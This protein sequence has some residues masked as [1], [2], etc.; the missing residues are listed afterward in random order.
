VG[1]NHGRARVFDFRSAAFALALLAGAGLVGASLISGSPTSAGR[2]DEF[3]ARG[4]S[5]RVPASAG[6]GGFDTSFAVGDDVT[7]SFGVV[8]V[9]HATAISGLQQDEISGGH[10]AANLVEPG[11]IEVRVGATITNLSS[12]VLPFA[13]GQFE[14]LD[15]D[16][17]VVP[18]SRVP[19]LPSELQPSASLEMVLGFV[20]TTQARPFTVR[21]ADPFSD[22]TRAIGLGTVGCEVNSGSGRPLPHDAGCST[23][24][25][26][27]DHGVRHEP[28]RTG[29]QAVAPSAEPLAVGTELAATPSRTSALHVWGL[30]L[31]VA[32]IF[33]VAASLRGSF[34]R[35]TRRGAPR[36][37]HDPL[38]TVVRR[39]RTAVIGLCLGAFVTSG[40][41]TT[42][43]GGAGALTPGLCPNGAALRQY[44]VRAI[45]VDIPLN[46]YGDHDPLGIMYA[47][48]SE[49]PAI[50]AQE[51]SGDVTPGLGEDPIQP[52]V[53][54]A[55]EGDC[56]EITLHN[57][58][59]R[60]SL[61][62]S[63]DGLPSDASGD[64]VGDN[65]N[66]EVLPGASRSYTYEIPNDPALEG[67][68]YLHP[69][70]G[71]R[72]LVDHGLFGA[73]VV[74]PPAST[75]RSQVDSRQIQSGWAAIIAPGNGDPA[76][77]ENVKIVHEVGN[78]SETIIGANGLPLPTVDPTTEAYRPGSRAFNYRA[79]PFMNRLLAQPNAKSHAYSTT[80]FGDPATIVA[81]GYV[82]EPTKFRV[83][84]AG[85][86]VFHVY[87]LHGGGDRWRLNP[88]A[89]PT[90]DYANTGL[91]KQPVEASL[92]QRVDAVST[93]PGESF[94]A[95]IE[96]GAG[97]VQQAAG[98]FLFH[99]HIAEHYPSGM[100]GLWRVFD[101]RQPGV[102][103]ISEATAPPL[104]V[105]S[106]QLIGRT[107]PGGVTLTAAN[108]AQWINPQL[109]PRGVPVDS[110]DATVWDWT[111][112]TIAGNPRYLGEPE[113][114]TSLPPGFVDGVAGHPG[115]FPG[116]Q[117]VGTRPAIL[118]NPTNG[119]PAFPLLR[120]HS[121][122]RPPFAPNE[123]SGAPWLGETGNTTSPGVDPWANRPDGL[124]PSTA[125]VKQFNIVAIN[126]P[127]PV[128]S[129]QSDA[130]GGIFTLAQDKAAILGGT[131]PVE[132]LA[133]RANVGDCVD[134]ILSSELQDALAF[135]G[136]SKVE[137]HI[138][139]VQFDPQG[140]DG[141]AAG[142]NFEHSI[143][144]YAATDTQLAAPAAIGATSV[145]V[146]ALRPRYRPGVAIAI[147]LGH[148]SVEN[149]TIAS[150]NAATNT[151]TLTEPLQH[152]HAIGEG[153]GT[154]FVR[155]R[156]YADGL[157]D[158]IFWHDHVDGIHGWGHGFVGM[159]IVEPR[160]STYTDPATG[161]PL[162]SGT[163]AD[164]HYN[165]VA[166][167]GGGTSAPLAP[168][169]VDGDFR[170]LVL[171]TIDDSPVTDSTIN[172]RAE[173]F[174]GRGADPSLWFS[175]Y[176]WGDPRTPLLRAYPGDSVV[177]RTVHV[178]PTIDS[179]RVDGHRF[180]VENRARDAVTGQRW[181]RVTDTM[182]AGVS[183]RFTLILDGGAGG[184]S[185]APGDYLY[186][187]GVS[188][189]F[190]QGAWGIMRVLPATSATLQPLANNAA[191]G[192]SYTA[193]SVTGTRPPALSDA[194]NPCPAAAYAAR[195]SFAVSA[196]RFPNSTGLS[197]RVNYAYVPT[198]QAAAAQLGG[199]SNPYVLHVNR[200][201]CI[202]INF[203]NDSNL[204]HAGF[205]VGELS[206]SAGS[207]GVNVGWNE[208]QTVAPGETRDYVFYADE[209]SIEAALV[210]DP[211]S[212]SIDPEEPL[213]HPVAAKNGLYGAIV[214]H[215]A[216]A[217]FTNPVSG[218]PT[219]LGTIVDVH[220]GAESYRDATL[221]LADDDV[222]LGNDFMPYPVD[223]QNDPM[224]NYRQ[225]SLRTNSFAG[226]PGTPIVRAYAGDPVKIHV[227]AA[228]GSEQPHAFH[229]SGH[230]WLRDPY[231]EFSEPGGEV[232]H[233]QE[234]STQMVAPNSGIDIHLIEGAGGRHHQVRDYWYGDLRRPFAEGGMWGLLRVMSDTACPIHALPTR[235]CA[236]APGGT[237]APVFAADLANRTD[238]EGSAISLSAAATDVDGDALVYAAT[239]LPPGLSIDPSSGLITG[240]LPFTAAGS[241]NVAITVRDGPLV[242]A[243]DTFTWTVSNT[244]RDPLFGQDLLDRTDAEADSISISSA[245]TDPDLEV[246]TYSA[247]GLPDGVSINS[248]TGLISGT[249]TF[250][251]AGLHNVAIRATDTAGGEATD[252]FTWTV[253]NVNREPTF[254]QDLGNRS[255][256]E[257][258]AVSLSAA[259][260][261][262]DGDP[263]T[264]AATNLPLGLTIDTSTGLITGTVSYVAAANS[265]Y[266]VTITVRD[267]ATIDATDSFVWTV[268][269][270]N[271]D[272]VF[273]QNLPDRSDGEGVTI[274]LSAA[275]TDLDGDPLTYAATNLPPGL[276]IDTST[277]LI[278]GTLPFTAAGL[279]SVTITVR[280]G[281]LVD[282]TDA[283][284]WTVTNTNREPTFNQNLGN[285]TDSE[286]ASVSLSA[287]ATDP[288]GD[289]LTYAATG[290]PAG[291]SINPTTGLIQGTLSFA[292]AGTHGVVVTV[293]DGPTID[294]ADSFTWTVLNVN[295]E[296]TFDQDLGDRATVEG[297]AV[298][299]SASATDPDGDALMYAAT[300]LPAGLAINTST[301][302]ISGTVAFT[303]AG[304]HTVS[305]TVRDGV[306]VDA[307]DTFTWTIID[308]PGAP[309]AIST[310]PGNAQ[311]TVLWLA[312]TTNGG[313]PITGYIVTPL[314][315]ST[316][317]T[318]RTFNS[319]ATTQ[320]ITGLTNGT[321]YTFQV[322]AFNVNG[323]G[324][325]SGNAGSVTVGTP[326]N[327]TNPKAV[328][329]N[330]AATVSWTA[331]TT[332]NGAA[333]TGYRVTPYIG[334]TAQTTVT[335]GTALSTTI[336]G[337]TNG[338]AYTFKIA[339]INS[340]GTGP[341]SGA[342]AAIT[343]GA[344]LAPTG[345][346][347]LAG[348]SAGRAT[349]SWLAPSS[350]N[351]A[352]IT[353]YVVT[354]YLAGVAQTPTTFSSTATSQQ[355]TGLSSGASYTFKVAAVNSR[356]TSPES[357]ATNA[358]VVP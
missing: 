323:V 295:R 354:P 57:D 127:V 319:T 89:D 256:G 327:P 70:P 284:V 193:P 50:R 247:T 292:S 318:P 283:F 294:A 238:S 76:F 334:T 273:N 62:L 134:V 168:G 219:T 226:D 2:T 78:E 121:L 264:Y 188:R 32:G 279:Y 26:T 152:A 255:T 71:H 335:V 97:G 355:I 351:G 269:N 229:I 192:G 274:S 59:G 11:S 53:I 211:G 117:F 84:H 137:M 223:A 176:R 329:G 142:L 190:R 199:V 159:F 250:A 173:P 129:T 350:N 106:D 282:A 194:G 343:V 77:R 153:A 136:F 169:L 239:G 196:V 122:H 19:Q 241:Y 345:A 158:N 165:P 348:P 108:L 87:H 9:E 95:E 301:G 331:P 353:G 189:R 252:T 118:F 28:R 113:Q 290:L 63:I 7:T 281:V 230:S 154:E 27:G 299:L 314:I 325:P 186:H 85:A 271:H 300:G 88:E 102:A 47:L 103:P 187:N 326:L 24:S 164:I 258:N 337:L 358:V 157:L 332:N 317:Q 291:L 289:P 145:Q 110:E 58:A 135:D 138:H 112:T 195:K 3:D 147:G 44:D 277:G 100:W 105:T 55:N 93:G 139:H 244:N 180:H 204:P 296:P 48:S 321:T 287:S 268:T 346:S 260:T 357:T 344:P 288:D 38:G 80:K 232:A 208:E 91:Q 310:L 349:V 308:T 25:V 303:A 111:T 272:P 218:F 4:G 224:V 341:Q 338:T 37:A 98:D 68:H 23:V 209:V 64:E 178:G 143:R 216:G 160:G 30:A 324:P 66:S 119:R 10:A 222:R 86:E 200:G 149:G 12:N 316:A 253:T 167:P 22:T 175:S 207:S 265:P 171:W 96:G 182:Q 213:V 266:S 161:L 146:Q 51:A 297:S 228:P 52:L 315:G 340:R 280:D 221:L 330:A 240:L 36:H 293:R 197:N 259:A 227:L 6:G 31:I 242:D 212:E 125:P 263:L 278:T 215:E 13:V 133:I 123:H 179:L 45:S 82:G 21:F 261:D 203:R 214:V 254:N 313:S 185:R 270:A 320:V 60:G 56:V 14:L 40:V 356:G 46:R 140:S 162:K 49:V 151:I 336:T 29:H 306:T 109:P 267:G 246:L 115:S 237:H 33:T 41:V 131:K 132:P 285:R 94:N 81:K 177:L 18:L 305:I 307:T 183:E 184:P 43:S 251:S 155:Y 148:D 298:S 150:V 322:R 210:S 312:P 276:T 5:S 339:A 156:W 166:L 309:T 73:L 249:L 17:N 236:G 163:L 174:A 34:R 231:L 201:D 116:D 72:N 206:K 74:E 257:G 311:A 54:R 347:A 275:A 75:W 248:A 42:S 101:T 104:P 65:G 205:S 126:V 107:M 245:A 328:P 144:P 141:T 333:I 20:T 124:C 198:S 235:T 286:N 35:S 243:T 262:L 202:E 302:L 120:P 170:E 8:A 61:G 1:A 128:T 225:G 191:P 39:L 130:A 233:S 220:L 234:L 15:R 69:G 181:S 67:T 92:S 304:T 352:A 114:T 83:L 99:C 16:G 90:H 79:E 217:T 342:S 172:L